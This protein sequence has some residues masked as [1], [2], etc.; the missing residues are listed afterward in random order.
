M[1]YPGNPSLIDL[2]GLEN[3]TS[4]G[5]TVQI[6]GN[7]SL[8]SLSGLNNVTSINGDLNIRSNGALRSL[9]GLDNITA[10]SVDNLNIWDN[11]SLSNC[12]VQSICDYLANPNGNISIVGNAPGCNSQEEVEAACGITSVEE[13]SVGDVLVI[14]PNP[15]EGIVDCQLSIVDCQR[16]TIKIYDFFGRELRVLVDEVIS[17]GEYTVRT[18]VSDLTA[19]VYLVKMQVGEQVE[20]VKVV[21]MR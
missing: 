16:V 1:Y 10:G 6:D 4:I 12:E 15:A 18:D 14:A 17:P 9:S 20:T 7:S 5:G 8:T 21:V 3:V 13:N 2:S 19:G 11:D